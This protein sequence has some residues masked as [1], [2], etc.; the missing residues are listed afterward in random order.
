MQNIKLLVV[1][2]LT[3]L[4]LSGFWVDNGEIEKKE[5]TADKREYRNIKKDRRSEQKEI[6]NNLYRY[7][8]KAK[9][10]IKK[11]YGYATFSN[12][13]VML[14]LAGIEMGDG[15]AHNNKT[16][17]NTYMGVVSI[18]LGAGL[19]LKNFSEIL[20]FQNKDA[21]DAFV[22]NGWEI[23]L[24]A[25]ASGKLNKDGKSVNSSVSLIPGI[26][27]YKLTDKGLSIGLSM[28]TTKYFRDEKLNKANVF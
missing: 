16:G 8:Y 5:S 11:A 21:F 22:N 19:G 26:K 13:S 25:E 1:L 2:I 10:V 7:D 14:A 28:Q 9:R 15:L 3:S 17:Q 20:V 18:G 24:T 23:N 12:R 27:L 4:F 6:L